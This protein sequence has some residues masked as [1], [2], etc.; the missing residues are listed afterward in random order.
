MAWLKL[1]LLSVPASSVLPFSLILQAM[2]F[3]SPGDLLVSGVPLVDD[4][5]V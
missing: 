3:G 2:R 4:E 5:V 1:W